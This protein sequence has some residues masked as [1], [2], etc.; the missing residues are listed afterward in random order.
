MTLHRF[1]EID[2]SGIDDVQVLSTENNDKTQQS[3]GLLSPHR[4]RKTFLKLLKK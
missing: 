4:S 3:I 2:N 1:W